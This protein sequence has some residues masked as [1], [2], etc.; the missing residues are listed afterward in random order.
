MPLLL[1]VIT[2]VVHRYLII[3]SKADNKKFTYKFIGAT[4]LKMFIYLVLIVIYLLLDRENAV[5]FL[6]YFL[7]LYVLYSF[8]EVFAVLKYLKNNK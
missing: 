2:L 8:F 5:P 3:A 1:F 6:I 4:G 7:I